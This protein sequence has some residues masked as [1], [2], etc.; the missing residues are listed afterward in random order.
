MH[1]L[2]YCCLRQQHSTAAKIAQWEETINVTDVHL[3]SRKNNSSALF[4]M[5]NIL[6]HFIVI[7]AYLAFPVTAFD[8]QDTDLFLKGKL[9]LL[10]KCH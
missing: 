2:Y 9:H 8:K 6:C 4:L 3:V 7:V 1:R 10:P 5:E